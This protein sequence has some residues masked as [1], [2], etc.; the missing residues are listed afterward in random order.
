MILFVCLFANLTQFQSK[1]IG[2]GGDRGV[3]ALGHAA[4]VTRPG[5]G[6]A[7]IPHLFMEEGFAR[8][9]WSN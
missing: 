6:S 8:E 5:L 4:K 3:N 9:H 2:G 1:V 7:M